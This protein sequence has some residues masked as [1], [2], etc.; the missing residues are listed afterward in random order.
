MFF[1]FNSWPYKSCYRSLGYGDTIFCKNTMSI[2][3]VMRIEAAALFWPTQFN[4]LKP[5][6]S[7][8]KVKDPLL[9]GGETG[10]DQ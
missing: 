9:G 1:G 8:P 7:L 10:L 5:E 2:Q 6:R 3:E 4:E